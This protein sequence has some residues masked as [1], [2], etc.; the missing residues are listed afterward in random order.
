MVIKYTIIKNHE[1]WV[2]CQCGETFDARAWCGHCPNCKIK[3]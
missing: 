3:Q 2:T 1:A